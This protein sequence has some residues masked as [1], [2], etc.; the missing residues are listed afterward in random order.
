VKHAE[1]GDVFATV[2][3]AEAFLNQMTG[4]HRDPRMATPEYKVTTVRLDRIE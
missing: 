1:R 2:H 3:T 4:P